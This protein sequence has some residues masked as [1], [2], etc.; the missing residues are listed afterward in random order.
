[1]DHLAQTPVKD[2]VDFLRTWVPGHDIFGPTAEGLGGA[3][4][5][6]VSQRP[7]EFA[8]AAEEMEGLDPTYVRCLF[9]S[10]TE[11]LKRGEKWDWGSVLNLAKWVVAQGRE[12]PGR[13]GGLMDADP[14]W[15]WSRTAVIDLLSAG[16]EGGPD[17]LPLEYRIPV[18]EVLQPLT[19][20]PNPG[21]EDESGEKF[22]PSS[23]SINSTRGRALDAVFDYA[24]WLRRCSDS[25]HKA[26]RQPPMTF[27]SMPEVRDVLEAHL[28]VERE[29]TLTI[30]STYGRHLT[31]LAGLDWDWLRTHV[32][33]ILLV[34]QDDP[35][36]F[37][38][39]WESFVSFNQPN[40]TLLPVLIPSYQRAVAQIGKIPPMMRRPASPEDRLAEH[41]MVYYWL[42]S[43]EFG[44][45]DGLLDGFYSAAPDE[46]RG[47]AT[48]FVGTSVSRWHDG[49]PPQVF[50]RLRN[51]IER[52]LDAAKQAASPEMFVE[53]LAN[54]GWWFTSKKFEERWS[55]ETL[56]SVLRLTKKAEGE[57]DVVKLL[58]E[59][60]PRYPV[61]CVLCLRLMVE[62]DR[63]RWLLLEVEGDAIELLK[64]AMA[65]NNP[66]AVSAARR[67]ADELIARGHFGF[68]TLLV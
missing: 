7:A 65:S 38:A 49:A 35:R 32:E 64:Q 47:Y 8:A 63:E 61:E 21:A 1:M 12:I 40:T 43:L 26:Q 30:R 41:L 60:C 20:D 53:E 56:L 25:A 17:R 13:K 45:A 68:R 39:A 29:P 18:W 58:L 48:W 37:S 62:G 57:M 19:D 66:D 23:L 36:P 15:G 2:I 54:F 5:G 51:L 9:G 55:L 44:S 27:E 52:R 24:W 50:D 22:D 28:N 59:R 46:L 10:L 16:F 34:A 42:G 67:L 11:A 3:F 4:A 6:A 31:A 33:R 14:D